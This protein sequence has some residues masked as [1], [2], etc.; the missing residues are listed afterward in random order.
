LR[1]ALPHDPRADGVAELLLGPRWAGRKPLSQTRGRRPTP[2]KRRTSVGVRYRE[3]GR[4][5]RSGGSRRRR[6][7]WQATRWSSPASRRG[8]SVV[9]QIAGPP[10]SARSWQRGLK[11]QPLGGLTGEGTSPRRMIRLR[12]SSGSGIGIAENRAL[13][14]RMLGAPE[15]CPGGLPAR[16]S[17]PRYMT[18]TRSL[19]CSTTAHVVGDEQVGQAE[20]ALERL[21][22]IEDLRLD[23]DV[24]GRDRLVADDDVGPGP[25]GPGRSRSAGAGRP[26]NSWGIAP[27]VVGGQADEIHDRLDAPSALRRRPDGRGCGAPRRCCRRS[28]S[29]GRATR[30]GPGR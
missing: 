15:T 5:L 18:A 22:L 13:R 10:S 8:G 6:G 14:V 26:R 3:G 27:V 23:R 17:F 2:V 24:E 28:A 7:K 16:R 11:W 19:M 12:R 25:P 21:E 9:A 20:L 30:T 1:P 29:A 4:G